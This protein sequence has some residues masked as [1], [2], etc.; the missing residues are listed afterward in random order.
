M[1]YVTRETRSMGTLYLNGNDKWVFAVAMAT[2]GARAF[3]E[4]EATSKV[5]E[6]K[7]AD[8]D[9]NFGVQRA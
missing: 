6:L 2:G 8:P 4:D 7:A 5:D 1:Y 3:T 9:T